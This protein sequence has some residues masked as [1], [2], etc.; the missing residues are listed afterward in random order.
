MNILTEKEIVC[1]NVHFKLMFMIVIKFYGFPLYPT[2]LLIIQLLFPVGTVKKTIAILPKS[3][4][5]IK[6][7]SENVGK[8]RRE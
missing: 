8:E 7:S 5:L 3:K 1:S 2:F 4:V 6:E